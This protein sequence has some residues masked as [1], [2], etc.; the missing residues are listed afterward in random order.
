MDLKPGT[1]GPAINRDDAGQA[2]FAQENPLVQSDNA[3]PR[4]TVHQQLSVGRASER[5]VELLG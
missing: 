4:N 3:Q 2:S 5:G 1:T